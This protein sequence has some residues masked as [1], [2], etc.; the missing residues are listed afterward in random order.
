MK[1]IRKNVFE[2]NSSSTHAICVAKTNIKNIPEKIKVNLHDYEFGWERDKRDGVD[3]KV[4][5]LLIGILNNNY[6]EKASKKVKKMFKILQENGV[7]DIKVSGLE[8]HLYG[9][10]KEPYFDT[11][12]GYVD[13]SSELED[14]VN[15]LLENSELLIEFL[16]NEDSFILTGNDNDDTD[17]SIN[18]DYEYEEFY[19]GN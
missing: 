10:S 17:I 5:Y 7:E 13:H 15:I 9:S 11:Y 2:T 19:K 6:I 14:F 8:I 12:D 18:V 16:F 4:A 1:V 3:E